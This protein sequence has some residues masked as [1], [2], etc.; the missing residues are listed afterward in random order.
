MDNFFDAVQQAVKQA[1]SDLRVADGQVLAMA[2]LIRGRLHV[3][4]A[5]GWRHSSATA[6]LI[7]LKRELQNFNA[8]TGKWKE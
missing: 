1:E 7:A 8:A 2:E 5:D 3:I 6:T 4:K